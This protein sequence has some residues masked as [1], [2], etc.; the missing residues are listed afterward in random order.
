M[1]AEDTKIVPLILVILIYCLMNAYS[2]G[3]VDPIPK[4]IMILPTHMPVNVWKKTTTNNPQ[5]IVTKFIINIIFGLSL[6][7][8]KMLMKRPDVCAAVSADRIMADLD[9]DKCITVF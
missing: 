8:V 6:I 5:L 3:L 1:P 9:D 7:D 2:P 4:P